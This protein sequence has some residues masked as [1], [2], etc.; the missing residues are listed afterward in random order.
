[1][2]ST[3]HLGISIALGTLVGLLLE[4]T[5]PLLLAV[6]YAGVLGVGIDLDHFLVARYNTGN[7]NAVR[8]CLRSP[9][10]VLFD[11]GAIFEPDAIWPI[12]RL[13]THVVAMGAIVLGLAFV[14]GIL[15]ILSAVVLYGHLLSDLLWDVWRH[16]EYLEIA[17]RY[18]ERNTAHDAGTKT[19]D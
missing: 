9:R 2:R 11:Q 18:V 16:D 4:P 14:D 5:I 12:E 6:A 7:W 13:L 1:M 17:A 8:T 15:A 19:N 3:H 10:V